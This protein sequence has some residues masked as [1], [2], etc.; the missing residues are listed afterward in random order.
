MVWFNVVCFKR[1]GDFESR[2][3]YKGLEIVIR[4]KNDIDF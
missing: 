1:I 4:N 3:R 2:G